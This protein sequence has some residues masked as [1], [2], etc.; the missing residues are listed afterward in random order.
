MVLLQINPINKPEMGFNP[1]VFY[2]NYDRFNRKTSME[3]THSV[4]CFLIFLKKYIYS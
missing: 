2:A 4:D 1:G 3:V